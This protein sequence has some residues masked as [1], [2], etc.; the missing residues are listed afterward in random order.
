MADP[1]PDPDPGH[2]SGH[3]QHDQRASRAA[4]ALATKTLAHG[5]RC[6][7]FLNRRLFGPRRSIV[8]FMS[9]IT[10]PAITLQSAVDHFGR[11]LRVAAS[12]LSLHGRTATPKFRSLRPAMVLCVISAF[13]GFAEDFVTA[14]L[15][16]QRY[17]LHQIADKADFNNPD[18]QIFESRIE[19][20]FPNAL[21][22]HGDNY[23]LELWRSPAGNS[24]WWAPI[25]LTW[26][27]TKDAGTAW[28]QVRHC[29]THGVAS[30]WE[31]QPWP[32]PRPPKQLTGQET[33]QTASS[34]LRE[35][36][37]GQYSLA[38]RCALNCCRVY[39]YGAQHLADQ[40]TKYFDEEHLDWANVPDFPLEQ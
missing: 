2:V 32:S 13:E 39:R 3:A 12:L 26:Q 1:D 23:G 10:E 15:Y 21:C 11:S 17:S 30:G 24:G 27:D 9:V 22:G 19:K 28:M 5:V 16:K 8:T 14:A 36:E 31:S 38:L 20:L 33:R 6:Y 4:L 40:V 35:T 7:G 29:L 25:M 18:L 34:V 37:P